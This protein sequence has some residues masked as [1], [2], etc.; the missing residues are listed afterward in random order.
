MLRTKT[1][2]L[3]KKASGIRTRVF[4]ENH[5]AQIFRYN[6]ISFFFERMSSA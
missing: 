5:A 4:S 2:V 1:D 6:N 3:H